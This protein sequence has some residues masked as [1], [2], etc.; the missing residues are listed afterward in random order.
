MAVKAIPDGYPVLTPYLVV[1]GAEKALEFYTHVFG[2]KERLRMQ[3]PDGKIMHAE[4][5]IGTSLLMLADPFPE[6]DIQAPRAGENVPV[7]L[8]LYVGD[9]DRVFAAAVEAGAKVL[10]PLAD[11]FY[12]DRAGSLR[13]P[14]GHTWTIATHVEDVSPDE[15][16]RRAQAAMGNG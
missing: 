16:Q 14:F 9:C 13:D 3:T 2:G 5:E 6:M 7:S 11:Q 4:I 12:G 8:L 15:T 10:R 1:Q